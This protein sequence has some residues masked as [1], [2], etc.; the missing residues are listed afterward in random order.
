MPEGRLKLAAFIAY[1]TGA[2]L[3]EINTLK[4]NNV[5]END[6]AHFVK[7]KGKANPRSV[8]ISKDRFPIFGVFRVMQMRMKRYFCAR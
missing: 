2:R 6:G 8:L 5:F 4:W 1:K 7:V 3:G